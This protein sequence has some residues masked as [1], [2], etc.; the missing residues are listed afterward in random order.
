M[1]AG[2]APDPPELPNPVVQRIPTPLKSTQ[3]RSL[4]EA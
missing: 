3:Q 1:G 2:L 4:R